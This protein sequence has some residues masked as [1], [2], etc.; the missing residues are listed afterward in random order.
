M[1]VRDIVKLLKKD[2]WYLIPRTGTSHKQFK[3]PTKVGRVT[4][5]GN[6]GD[7]IAPGTLK[8]IMRQAQIER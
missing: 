6:D 7:D 5:S 8:S 3:H 1:K 2:G 4:V